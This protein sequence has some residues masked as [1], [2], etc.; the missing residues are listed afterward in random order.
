VLAAPTAVSAPAVPP[1]IRAA[2]V[3]FSYLAVWA[4]LL[5]GLGIVTPYLRA[6]LQ[7]TDFQAG[8]H[9]SALA[10]G[11]LAAG[12][13]ADWVARR[14]GSSWLIDVAVVNIVVG[15]GLIAVAPS[16]PVSLAGALFLGLGGGTLGTDVNVRLGR[17][18]GVET[19]KLMGQANAIAMVMAG[20]A[21]LAVGLAASG[22][23][24]WRVALFLPVVAFLGL[25][26]IRPRE[27]EAR[28]QVRAPS[29]TLPGAYWFAWLLLVLFVSIEFS[30]VYWG[31]TIVAKQTGLSGADATLLASLFMAGMFVGRAAIGRGIGGRRASHGLL[32]GGLCL[33][34]VGA[35][36]MWVSTMPIVSGIGLFVGGLGT[37]GLWPIGLTVALQ[38]APKAPLQAAARA[39]L[40]SG[41]AVLLAPSALGLAADAVGVVSAWPI[42]LGLAV[43]GLAVVA[44]TPRST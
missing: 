9:A 5:Y 32:A 28:S 38:S 8:L 21:P 43:A 13:S 27:S 2:W 22:L 3:P 19:R 31:S 30:F 37:A 18:G 25:A 15:I 41:F 23:H 33:V 6:D 1:G 24:A 17:S 11:T 29:S 20:A 26:V 44:F 10:V 40:G 35:S 16:L 4:Y 36:L 7:L 12:I 34:L 14:I 39:T 42:V